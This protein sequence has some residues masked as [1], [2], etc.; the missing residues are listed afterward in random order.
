[1]A[2]GKLKQSA[3]DKL[4]YAAYKDRYSKNKLRSL[5][6]T[7]KNQPNNKQA[8]DALAKALDKGV[9]YTRNRKINGH[10]CKGMYNSLGF[11]NNQPSDS[12]KVVMKKMGLNIHWFTGCVVEF[13]HDVPNH[14]KTIK[15]QLELYGY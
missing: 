13:N 15:E 2:S 3:S 4:Q 8:Q 9:K 10:K 5:E 14:G 12:M 11:E 6:R 1:M 7:A